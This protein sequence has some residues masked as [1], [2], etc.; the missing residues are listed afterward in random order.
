MG[1][2]GM[3]GKE[4]DCINVE[5]SCGMCIHGEYYL[6]LLMR[7]NLFLSLSLQTSSDPKPFSQPLQKKVRKHR[8][9]SVLPV[10]FDSR[11]HF[12]NIRS[13]FAVRAYVSLRAFRLYLKDPR[14]VKILHRPSRSDFSLWPLVQFWFF[15]SCN[16]QLH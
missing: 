3:R 4:V 11:C 8:P 5:F 2:R 7:L 10:Y 13:P 1:K 6:C 14:L 12:C 16:L 15:V 9:F